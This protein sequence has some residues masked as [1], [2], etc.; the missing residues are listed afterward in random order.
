MSS[1]S[2][3]GNELQQRF[4]R[5]LYGVTEEP[6]KALHAVLDKKEEFTKQICQDLM[7]QLLGVSCMFD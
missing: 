6:Q 5:D 4:Y 1:A 2:V 3:A 7:S